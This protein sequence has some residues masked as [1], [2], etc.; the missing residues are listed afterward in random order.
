MT[1]RL[2]FGGTEADSVAVAEV[3]TVIYN[4][5]VVVFGYEFE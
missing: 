2:T 3:V 4:G 5:N 1:A